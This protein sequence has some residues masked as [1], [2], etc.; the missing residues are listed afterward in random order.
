MRSASLVAPALLLSLAAAAPLSPTIPGSLVVHAAPLFVFGGGSLLGIVLGR[1][2]LVLGLMVLAVAA[3]AL[4]HFGTR[5]TFQAVALLMPL[6]LGIVACLGETRV[7]STR[8]A[9]WLGGILVQAVAVGLYQL[10]TPAALDPSLE[11]PLVVADAGTWTSLPKLGVVAFAAMLGLHFARFAR[12]R[13]P[14]PAAT[15][16]ALVASFLALDTA[17]SGGPAEIHLSAAGL[18]LAVGALLEPPRALHLDDVTGLPASLEFNRAVQRLPARYVLA[19]VAID[20]LRTF[21]EEHGAEA[22]N[23]MLRL[24]ARAL[25]R[26]G[27]G[28]RVFYLLRAHEFVVLFRRGSV[29]AV[30]RH[31]EAVRRAVE[32]ASLDVAVTERVGAD[33]KATRVVRRSVSVTISAGVVEPPGP[34]ADPHAM[35]RDAEF[36]LARA[37]ASG[38]NRVVGQPRS[39][40]A[41]DAE[42]ALG[43]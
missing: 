11:R 8:G 1:G 21:R 9:W 40:A 4:S 32:A 19:C 29:A 30:T 15:A 26:M 28:G 7:L 16:W 41:A 20:E 5:T 22:A 31:L 14:L 39:D 34:G 25:R 36:A 33:R 13:R 38:M 2:R 24:V 42:E 10:L 23:R 43:L 35:L 6:N 12:G 3:G 18:L 37:Q 17:G 27:G